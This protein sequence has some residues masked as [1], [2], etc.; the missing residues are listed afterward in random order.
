MSGA[1]VIAA[2]LPHSQVALLDDCGHSVSL[3]RPR[4]LASLLCHFLS[5]QEVSDGHFL[6]QQEVSDGDFLS[7][8]E[9]RNG[10]AEKKKNC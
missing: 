6:S 2:A 8:Q 7:Q 10:A 1:S 5:Q 4:K 3:E 9:V